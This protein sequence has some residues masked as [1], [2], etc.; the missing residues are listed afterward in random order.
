LLKER[1]DVAVAKALEP[2]DPVAGKL[3]TRHHSIDGHLGELKELRDLAYGI[4]FRPNFVLFST[5]PFMI[6]HP[7][8]PAIKLAVMF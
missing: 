8:Q 4:E 5:P 6:F 7:F 3:L 2:P 1:F